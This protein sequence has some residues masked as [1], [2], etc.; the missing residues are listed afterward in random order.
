MYILPMSKFVN[1]L[2][3][4][5]NFILISSILLCQLDEMH[6]TDGVTFT[7]ELRCLVCELCFALLCLELPPT[8]VFGVQLGTWLE[9]WVALHSLFNHEIFEIQRIFS[10]M[11]ILKFCRRENFTRDFPGKLWSWAWFFWRPL[12]V[13]NFKIFLATPKLHDIFQ[14]TRF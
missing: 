4:I 3:G 1:K 7:A 14:P 5:Y 10:C 8:G 13:G 6:R 2:L 12:L 9:T 11:M